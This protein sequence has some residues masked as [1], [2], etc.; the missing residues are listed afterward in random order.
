M[1]DIL[2]HKVLYITEYRL[3]IRNQA[4]YCDIDR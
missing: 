3:S 1:W 2:V 4:C